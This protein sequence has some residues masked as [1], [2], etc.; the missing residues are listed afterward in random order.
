V[1]VPRFHDQAA[2]KEFMYGAI[3]G[4]ATIQSILT[5]VAVGNGLYAVPARV[6]VL[7]D[8][9]GACA[10]GEHHKHPEGGMRETPH[11]GAA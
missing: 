10:N 9:G 2:L 4:V 6:P 3:H 11:C 1:T 8:A 7:Y 5:R